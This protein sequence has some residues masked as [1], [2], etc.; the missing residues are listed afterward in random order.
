MTV[1]LTKSKKSSFFLNL[2]CLGSNDNF[3]FWSKRKNNLHDVDIPHICQF[4]YTATF[5]RPVNRTPKGAYIRD[6][7]AKIGQNGPKK[8]KISRSLCLNAGPAWNKY[9]TSGCSGCDYFKLWT[10]INWG[11]ESTQIHIEVH[12]KEKTK[13][14]KIN[15]GV[16]K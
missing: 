9:T 16:F 13:Y 5:F 12:F 7:I 11:A 4:R 1:Y 3:E 14:K 6:K 8:A 10:R 15:W 2:S